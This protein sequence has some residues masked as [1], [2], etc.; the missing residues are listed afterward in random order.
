MA[1]IPK[2]PP[3]FATCNVH[4]GTQDLW[5]QGA[6]RQVNH[7]VRREV[8]GTPGL[9]LCGLTRFDA[10]GR[11]ADLPGW[12]IGGGVSGPN[13][14]QT[15]CAACWAKASEVAAPEEAT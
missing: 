12:S 8:H 7:L 1:D 13:I 9:T 11:S 14:E 2:A 3:G 15:P 10:Y 5:A 4:N 6:T